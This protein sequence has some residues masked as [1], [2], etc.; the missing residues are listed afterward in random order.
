MRVHRSI[1]KRARKID[2]DKVANQAEDFLEDFKAYRKHLSS[3]T[4]IRPKQLK[5]MIKRVDKLETEIIRHEKKLDTL[6]QRRNIAAAKLE[7]E[8]NFQ[9]EIFEDNLEI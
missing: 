9:I 8:L 7:E 5:N 2:A 1:V 4:G 6:I 3:L